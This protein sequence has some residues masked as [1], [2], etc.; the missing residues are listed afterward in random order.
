MVWFLLLLSLAE[1]N[2]TPPSLKAQVTLEGDRAWHLGG[3]CFGQ[4]DDE[5]A[6][7]RV[8]FNAPAVLPLRPSGAYLVWFDGREDYWG[9]ARKAWHNS[10]CAEKLARSTGYFHLGRTMQFEVSISQ[11]S[12]TRDWH[13]S[14]V[15]CGPLPDGALDLEVSALH[16]AQS[17][18]RAGQ[19]FDD[20]SCPVMPHSW[21][22]QAS[23]EPGMWL[24]IGL[25]L[26][27]GV[28]SALLLLHCWRRKE[29]NQA[30]KRTSN[31]NQDVV[32]GKP[33]EA[34]ENAMQLHGKVVV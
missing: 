18:F 14:L 27:T 30:L 26:S 9:A 20:T 25:A 33:C 17:I 10:S 32:I 4:A 15:T 8:S 28:A 29:R 5:V 13:F 31:I 7:L 24:L 16:G 23:S 3:F 22:Q 1:G 6:R 12:A 21:W 19:H 34:S 11:R 2:I